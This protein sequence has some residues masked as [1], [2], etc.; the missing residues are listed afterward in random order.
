MYNDRLSGKT[1][2]ELSKKYGIHYINCSLICR[3]K[4]WK[5]LWESK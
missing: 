3:K 4:L 2:K 5:H 1:Y